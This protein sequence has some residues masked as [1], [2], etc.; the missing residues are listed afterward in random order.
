LAAHGECAAPMI[1]GRVGG[2]PSTPSEP[3]LCPQFTRPSRLGVTTHVQRRTR[4]HA[5]HQL[6]RLL[7]RN[8]A[9]VTP[10]SG[11]RK[12]TFAVRARTR[13]GAQALARQRLVA[14]TPTDSIAASSD[15]HRGCPRPSG[16]RAPLNL[17]SSVPRCVRL[18]RHSAAICDLRWPNTLLKWRRCNPC[19]RCAMFARR[20]HG[21]K[22]LRCNRQ[23]ARSFVASIQMM[24]SRRSS[25]HCKISGVPP[26]PWAGA[27]SHMV[28]TTSDRSRVSNPA[29]T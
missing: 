2:R 24:G 29:A 8:S 6:E 15:A 5:V 11:P 10:T 4:I 1:L 17:L 13:S 21:P 20:G 16:S 19:G 23:G 7:P 3:N 28:S 18:A 9:L 12:R 26:R 27:P 25:A 22:A 14:R